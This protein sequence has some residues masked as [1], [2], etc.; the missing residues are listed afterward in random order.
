M[1][2]EYKIFVWEGG[3]TLQD[4]SSGMIVVVARN[5]EEALKMIEGKCDY[6]M[7]NFRVNGYK[8]Y[9]INEANVWLVWG[10]S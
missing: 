4:C 9:P 5:L 2:E 6:C 10:G 3:G 1:E 8:T 7:Q